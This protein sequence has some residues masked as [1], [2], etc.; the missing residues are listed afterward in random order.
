M[1]QYFGLYEQP[2]ELT[3]TPKINESKE[4]DGSEAPRCRGATE[5][6]IIASKIVDRIVLSSLAESGDP[7]PGTKQ[8]T[9]ALR[10]RGASHLSQHRGKD[11][12]DTHI[13]YKLWVKMQF[14]I[15]KFNRQGI[16]I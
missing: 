6:D 3:K 13:G 2:E 1:G 10:A 7:H 14:I 8:E 5:I 4:K 9:L 16:H 12:K 11:I 15:D